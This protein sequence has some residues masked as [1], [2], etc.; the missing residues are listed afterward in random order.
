MVGALDSALAIRTATSTL[1]STHKAAEFTLVGAWNRQKDNCCNDNSIV[2]CVHEGMLM[3][4]CL[5]QTL[6]SHSSRNLSSND[7]SR[8]RRCPVL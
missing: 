8:I 2:H 4:D 5:S 1:V 7:H 6:N 3:K